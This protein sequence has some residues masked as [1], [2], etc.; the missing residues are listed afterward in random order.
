MKSHPKTLKI[1]SRGIEKLSE[2]PDSA[3][4]K[5]N[6]E[7]EKHSINSRGKIQ[8]KKVIIDK[9]DKSLPSW[10]VKTK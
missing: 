5:K 4:P 7:K 6:F 2:T 8:L 3:P 1:I 10:E 9:K